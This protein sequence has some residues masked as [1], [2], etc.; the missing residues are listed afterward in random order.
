[1]I[2]YTSYS[3]IPYNAIYI[4]IYTY[5][6]IDIRPLISVCIYLLGIDIYLYSYICNIVCI[7]RGQLRHI[8]TRPKTANSSKHLSKSPDLQPTTLMTRQ[9]QNSSHCWRSTLCR[10]AYWAAWVEDQSYVRS[11]C[12]ISFTKALMQY[13]ASL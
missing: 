3:S 8:R 1:M 12:N 11:H 7:S 9:P 4:Y 13:A 6:Y 2:H 5:T 10:V